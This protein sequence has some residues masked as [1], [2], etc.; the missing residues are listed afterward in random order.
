[1]RSRWEVQV[2]PPAESTWWVVHLHISHMN[3]VWIN[4]IHT[5]ICIYDKQMLPGVNKQY[6]PLQADMTMLILFLFLS[7]HIEGSF[8]INCKY[9]FPSAR[10]LAGWIW[11]LNERVASTDYLQKCANIVMNIEGSWGIPSKLKGG[12]DRLS[13]EMCNINMNVHCLR[14]LYN[15]NI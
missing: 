11:N 6:P 5:N 1:M 2:N 13:A 12:L 15:L 14:I 8:K 7:I 9:C 3:I 10:L 4:I